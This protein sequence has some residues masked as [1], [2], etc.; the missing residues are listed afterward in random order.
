MKSY[1]PLSHGTRLRR[2][3]SKE[4]REGGGEGWVGEGRGNRWETSAWNEEFKQGPWILRFFL[5]KRKLTWV[6]W[7][8]QSTTYIRGR[9]T[10]EVEREGNAK[11]HFT[12]AGRERETQNLFRF[13][14]STPSHCK[15]QRNTPAFT[16]ASLRYY[17]RCRIYL[18]VMINLGTHVMCIY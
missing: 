6:L 2:C 15:I 3:C 18:W 10:W 17:S 8:L 12:R 11:K 14:R 4:E 9:F 16:S 13:A 1:E 5:R 7:I